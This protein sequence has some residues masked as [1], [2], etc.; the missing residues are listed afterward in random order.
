[1]IFSPFVSSKYCQRLILGLG[2]QWLL[3]TTWP[4]HSSHK[5][6]LRVPSLGSEGYCHHHQL[7]GKSGWVRAMPQEAKC[8]RGRWVIVQ[9]QRS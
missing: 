8:Q 9:K 7:D 6:D 2:E 4:G 3:C 1:M 5:A